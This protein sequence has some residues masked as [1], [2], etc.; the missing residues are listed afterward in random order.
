MAKQYI[1]MFLDSL[2]KQYLS[3]KFPIMAMAA[4]ALKTKKIRFEPIGQ[5]DDGTVS[6]IEYA[7]QRFKRIKEAD[8]QN[9]HPTAAGDDYIATLNQAQTIDWETITT[10]RSKQR[11]LLI[12]VKKGEGTNALAN[13]TRFGATI[14]TRND[15]KLISKEERA[16]EK[17]LTNIDAQG[18]T[19]TLD[20]TAALTAATTPQE[21][22]EVIANAFSHTSEDIQEHI[23]DFKYNDEV[24]AIYNPRIGSIFSLLQGKDYQ[25]GTNTFGSDYKAGFRY[26]E[27][28]FVPSTVLKSIGKVG[29]AGDDTDKITI[30]IILSQTS[31]ADAGLAQ[32]H[33][34]V[35]ESLPRGDVIGHIYDD[36]SLIVDKVRQK[37]IVATIASL[38]TAGLLGANFKVQPKVND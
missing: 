6:P 34:E 33:I 37:K 13:A 32:G 9:D 18:A 35:N 3:G 1:K 15:V 11:Q 25:Q 12:S 10:K 2:E 20:I 24:L 26:A 23:D 17:I 22:R 8:Q 7:I 31:Y 19:H 38:K 16:T 27:L 21:K 5:Y 30:G 28:D 14:D 36:L 29:A 4:R